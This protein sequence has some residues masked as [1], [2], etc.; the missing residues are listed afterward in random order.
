MFHSSMTP[1]RTF[2][3]TVLRPHHQPRHESFSGYS[4]FVYREIIPLS[5]YCCSSFSSSEFGFHQR[6]NAL[7]RYVFSFPNRI[8]FSNIR[9][10]SPVVA[11][12]MR[13]IAKHSPN[14]RIESDEI[15]KPHIISFVLD[16]RGVRQKSQ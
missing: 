16:A 5:S 6:F 9:P 3:H 10:I 8:C 11:V 13:L 1:L 7:L 2:W 15:S 14:R 4:E 12:V